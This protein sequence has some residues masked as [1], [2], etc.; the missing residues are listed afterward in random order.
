[1]IGIGGIGMSALAQVLL[2]RGVTVSGSDI[3]K[4]PLTDQLSSAG[5]TVFIGHS[6]EQV[7]G[8]QEVVISDAVHQEN[9]ELS[10]ARALG[11]PVRRRS[12]LLGS[13]MLEARGL[14]VAGTHGKTTVTAMIG[15]ILADSGADPTVILGGELPAIGGNARAGAGDWFVAEACEAYESFL[16]LHP[17]IAVLTNIEADHLD[18]HKTETHLRESFAQFVQTLPQNGT[19]VV[20]A[21][22]SE[23]RELS[24]PSGTTIVRYGT[25]EE[26]HVRGLRVRTSG[27]MGRCDL[28]VE[29][30]PAG[31]LTVGVPGDHNI[32]NAL[33]ATAAA[34][35]AGAKV[36]DCQ[37]SLKRFSGVGRRFELVGEGSDITVVDDYAHHPT[38]IDATIAA[39]RDAFSG[40]RIVALFQPHLYS[41]TRDF[42]ESFAKALG[43]ADLAVLTEIYPAREAPIPGISSG[44]IADHMRTLLGK[45]AVTEMAK[46]DVVTVL[47]ANLKAG[48]V[49]LVMGAGDIGRTARELAAH[50]GGLPRPNRSSITKQ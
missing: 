24:P 6:A 29:G 12:E 26:S 5:A 17:E 19:L 31:E 41:R 44:L 35:A 33:G 48:D 13:L 22:R 11:L 23:L 10:R 43:S 32:M 47:P 42:A 46:Q 45:D 1:M 8:A 18:H 39:A 2:A 27:G 15:L 30:E 7:E 38:E 28:V 16:H 9:P 4:S 21:D 37:R 20:C 25:D 40:R 50:L 36:E 34:L 49:V 14:A 3:Q